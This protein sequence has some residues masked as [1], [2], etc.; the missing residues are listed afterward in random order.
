VS[1]K[2][3][4]LRKDGMSLKYFRNNYIA[5]KDFGKIRGVR[6]LPLPIEYKSSGHPLLA[7]KF[8][9]SLPIDPFLGFTRGV[10]LRVL[11]RTSHTL[12]TYFLGLAEPGLKKCG[13]QRE[14][15]S[16]G[17]NF[18]PPCFTRGKKI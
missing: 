8:I 13:P 15:T 7:K 17:P 9:K 10:K 18:I 1:S 6:P 2:I 3:N 4:R 12:L 11:N 5:A 16:E 14:L